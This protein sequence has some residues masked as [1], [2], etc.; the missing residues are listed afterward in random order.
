MASTTSRPTGPCCSERPSGTPQAICAVLLGTSAKR[1]IVCG[2][3]SCAAGTTVTP[4]AHWLPVDVSVNVYWSMGDEAPASRLS[5]DNT[6]TPLRHATVRPHPSGLPDVTK[7]E[8]Q[9]FPPA[10]L[11]QR[12]SPR[13]GKVLIPIMTLRYANTV[14]SRPLQISSVSSP[15]PRLTLHPLLPTARFRALAPLTQDIP[16]EVNLST[17]GMLGAAPRNRHIRAGLGCG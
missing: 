4:R 3:L 10:S 12:R 2:C 13:P 6:R 11:Q 14:L 16:N 1:P 9:G 8:K 15:R 7:F 17:W 5:F